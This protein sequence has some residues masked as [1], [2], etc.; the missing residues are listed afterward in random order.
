MK[1]SAC[2]RASPSKRKSHSANWPTGHNQRKNITMI[3]GIE[4]I[5]AMFLKGECT[6]E[7]AL[8]W[9]GSHIDAA[10]RDAALLD[11]FAATAAIGRDSSGNISTLSAKAV[12]GEEPPN[13]EFHPGQA[14]QRWCDAEARIR[15]IKASSMMKARPL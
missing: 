13:W 8:Q 5:L 9:I 12:M 3:P 14:M 4:D 15:Y 6:Q 10:T 2:F 1:P 7:Q 11:H